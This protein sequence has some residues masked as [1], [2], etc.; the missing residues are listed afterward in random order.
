M[1]KRMFFMLVA[2]IGFLAIIGFVKFKQIQG[3][4]AQ[5]KAWTPPPEA[6]TT[7]VAAQ[8][9]WTD[10]SSA[11]GT[12]TA[13]NGVTLTADLAGIVES[14]AFESGQSVDKGDLIAHLDTRQEEAALVS[15]EAKRELDRANFER[16]KDLL[17]QKVIAQ[18]DYD[19]AAAAYDQSKAAVVG[20]QATIARKTLRAP[21]A[22]VLGIRQIN[23]GQYMNG[24]DPIVSLQSLDPIYV[25]FG[26]PQQQLEH[27]KRG[28]PVSITTDVLPGA[29]F[30]GKITAV[31]SV[32]DPATR[33]AHVQATLPNPEGKL[34]PGMFVRAEVELPHDREVVPIPASAIS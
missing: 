8:E 26:T 29:A 23:L 9:T 1:K 2:V 17:A 31:D 27:M 30:K 11:V 6:V 14:I 15:A 7:V 25:N 13:V 5:G 4:I 33:N 12:V 28:V 16:A 34:K 19:A 3:A 24:G 32:V 21:F 22:G 20:I 18:A 10:T